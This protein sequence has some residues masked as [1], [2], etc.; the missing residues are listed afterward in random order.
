MISQT[1]EYALRAVVFLAE[2]RDSGQT[3]EQIAN[4]TKIPAAYLSKVMQQL[5]RAQLV[6]SQRGVGGGFSMYKRA[7]EVS[8]L[9]VVNAVD[10]IERI[11][12][13]PLKLDAHKL[14]L[15]PLHKRVDEA[16]A[17]V[18]K[19]FKS[20]SI[21]DLL[22][23]SNKANVYTFPLASGEKRKPAKKSKKQG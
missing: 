12:E 4:A 2:N 16:T 3:T 15:C 19:A 22:F 8:V 13:C 11:R 20:T 17:L 23:D 6:R 9:D 18:E 21:A 5:S 14:K 10:P 7:K 1:A